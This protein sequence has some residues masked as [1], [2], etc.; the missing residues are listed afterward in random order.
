MS[1]EKHITNNKWNIWF[2]RVDDRNWLIDSY[3]NIATIECL[4]EYKYY[5]DN[6]KTF[7]SGMFFIMK[8]NIPPLWEDTNNINGGIITYKITK[9]NADFIWREL[10][11]GLLGNTLIKNIDDHKYINGISI[12]PKIN[13]C[14]IKIWVNTSKIMTKLKFNEHI[15]LF[16]S[17]LQPIYKTFNNTSY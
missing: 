14:I 12:S 2:H 8:D 4:E 3:N 16:N 1:L 7:T 5:Y 15:G 17:N 6:I 11:M 9:K 13:N 10:T